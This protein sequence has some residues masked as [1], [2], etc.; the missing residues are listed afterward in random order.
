VFEYVNVKLIPTLAWA[1][2]I[3]YHGSKFGSLLI[4]SQFNS[5]EDLKL[6][7]ALIILLFGVLEIG[8]GILLKESLRYLIDND[9]QQA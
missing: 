3:S 7:M 8:G 5:C 9:I 4:F 1:F 6:I 2:L